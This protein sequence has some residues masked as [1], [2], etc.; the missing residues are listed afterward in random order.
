VNIDNGSERVPRGPLR[1]RSPG[2]RASF[3]AAITAILVSAT[4]CTTAT[5]PQ[6]GPASA[7]DGPTTGSA[8]ASTPAEQPTVISASTLSAARSHIRHVV[9]IVKENHTFDNL[10]GT[11]P[12]ADGATQGKECDGSTVPLL[13]APDKPNDI[14]HSFAGGLIAIDGGRMDCFDKLPGG[15]HGAGYVEYHSD[16][17]PDYFAYASHFAL[18]DRF[19]SSIYGPTGV[20]HLWTVASQSDRFVDHVRSNMIGNQPFRQY[21]DDSAERALSFKQLTAQQRDEAFALEDEPDPDQLAQRFWIYRWPCFDIPVLPDRLQQAGVTWRYYLGPGND[22]AQPLRMIRHVRYGPE[23]RHV[24][25]DTAFLP[26]L[27][28]GHLR[29]MSWLVPPLKLSDHPPFSICQGENWSVQILNA[30]QHSPDWRSTAV[31]LTWDDFGG[32]YDHVPPPHVDLYGYGPRVPAIIISPWVRPGYIEHTTLDF[33]SVIRTVEVLFR[34][35][36]LARRDTLASTL[37][38]AFDFTRVPVKPLFRHQQ[39]CA[40]AS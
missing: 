37:F 34:L 4:V 7:T 14:N 10:F 16:Q 29:S 22:W 38:D 17:L 20:E 31:I 33:S 18:A 25:S 5:N 13:R 19:F 6:D 28:H 9:F 27:E 12:G 1:V 21:C 24:V 36:P 11:F 3:A 30:L 35:E 2:R 26:D 8:S 15:L 40:G 32:F 23:W 39:S